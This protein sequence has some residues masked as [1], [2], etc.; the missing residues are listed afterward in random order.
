MKIKGP[1]K[2]SIHK[3]WDDM[4]IQDLIIRDQMIRINNIRHDFTQHPLHKEMSIR[5]YYKTIYE[6]QGRIKALYDK[7]II[8]SCG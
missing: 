8:L 5:S 3:I 1:L 6:A 7:E 2:I 4:N